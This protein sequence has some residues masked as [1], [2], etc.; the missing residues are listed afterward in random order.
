[1][2]SACR[3]MS[4]CRPLSASDAGAPRRAIAGRESEEQRRYRRRTASAKPSSRR[5]IGRLREARNRCGR[6]DNRRAAATAARRARPS[7]CRRAA[8]SRLST[9]I[10]RISLSPRRPQRQAY[11]H[12]TRSRG[13]APKQQPGNVQAGRQE[14]R[15]DGAEQDDQRRP[16]V[17]EHVVEQRGRT[18]P[19][20]RRWSK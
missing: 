14:H 5:S 2:A 16:V 13:G 15:S 1:M 9:S 8:R 11:R 17:A 19:A 6:R 20:S 3:S 10:C 18:S 4:G 7:T 12:L